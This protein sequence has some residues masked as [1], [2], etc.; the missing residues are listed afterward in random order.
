MIFL[1]S[2]HYICMNY[3]GLIVTWY[4]FNRFHLM[5]MLAQSIFQFCFVNLL[6]C[7]HIRCPFK[8]KY[9]N[10]ILKR[11]ACRIIRKRDLAWGYYLEGRNLPNGCNKYKCF[12]FRVTRVTYWYNRLNFFSH[13]HLVYFPE[14]FSYH[15]ISFSLFQPLFP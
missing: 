5:W 15:K 14:P 9:N 7:F 8:L 12:A 11:A 13:L 6:I 10:A 2:A 1:P 4:P 3:L